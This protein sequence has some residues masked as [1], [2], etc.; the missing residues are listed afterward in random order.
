MFRP[1]IQGLR[2]V[3]VGVVL[4]FHANAPFLPGGFVG[5]DV[6]FVISGYLITG[7]LL[8]EAT[9]T[10]RIRLASFYAKRA[11]RILPAAT[12][13][14]VATGILTVLFLPQ[15]RWQ[16]IGIEIAAAAVYVVNWVLAANTDYLNADVAASPL[17]HF[18]TLAVEEQ[19]YIVWPLI[20]LLLLLF[21]RRLRNEQTRNTATQWSLRAGV[22]ILLIPSLLW[23]V[24]YTAS[25]PAPAY[26][27]TTTRLWELAI[28]ALVAVFAVQLERIPTLP[29]LIVGWVGIG[30]IA[31]AS[32]FYTAATPFPGAAALLPTLGAAAV[33]VGGMNGRS[34][35][36][37][38]VLLSI[39]P[40][41]WVGD[42]SYSLYLWHWPL[43]VVAT[44]MLGEELR[45]RHGIIV[46]ILSFVPAWLSYRLIE[47]PFRNWSR[48][49]E[50]VSASLF[51]GAGLMLVSVL[52]GAGVFVAPVTRQGGGV[53]PST[54]LGAMALV[55][56]P[57]AG[58]PVDS[59]PGGFTPSAIEARDDNSVIYE[60]GCHADQG[61]TQ[62]PGCT[63]GDENGDTTVALVGDSHAANWAPAMT[64]LA[65]KHGW[66]LRVFTKSACPFADVVTLKGEG[67][68]YDACT[69]WNDRVTQK[70]I[71]EQPD[72]VVTSNSAKRALWDDGQ[73][74][75]AQSEEPFAEG[76]RRT[77]QQLND[78]G[79]PVAVLQD[80][81]R[82]GIDV[83][84]CVSA[85]PDQLTECAVPRAEAVDALSTPEIPAQHGMQD[86]KLIN[87]NDWIC[88]AASCAPVIGNV[89]IWR[90]DQHLTATYSNSL[91]TPLEQKLQDSR[92]NLGLWDR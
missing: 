13:V 53:D 1:D 50:R 61:F 67:E 88:P 89:L 47:N 65:E 69:D 31:S 40:M 90:D 58:E 83:P 86:T 20:I 75:L 66:R 6:F 46:V 18:W 59:V 57:G 22:L 71:E 49:K 73:L 64:P 85:H 81:P 63:L 70:L 29:G 77:W 87:M 42:I 26:F 56:D 35:R 45:F 5:V 44:Y 4:L 33:I 62:N 32:I 51:A 21:V 14:L 54:A 12:I 91:V 38:G 11:R 79:I 10:G 28:G 82:M 92:V 16:D 15:I 60:T 7:I 39:R 80:I 9:A 25:D 37:V 78:A 30:G 55:D 3:A 52:V 36:G 41:R 48:L 24:T 23:S 72:L 43:V 76:L 68:R 34:T 8:R 2:A 74:T 17:Q 27:A 19:F 84:E